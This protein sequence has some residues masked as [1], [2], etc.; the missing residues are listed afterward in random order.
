M[1]GLLCRR[2]LRGG[3]YAGEWQEQDNDHAETLKHHGLILRQLFG[4]HFP[5]MRRRRLLDI[6]S[7]EGKMGISAFLLITINV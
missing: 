1:I 6:R 2:T 3:G 7:Q 5:A 4:C